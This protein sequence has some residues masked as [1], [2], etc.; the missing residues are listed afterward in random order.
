MTKAFLAGIADIPGG[1][2]Y[3][4]AT[5]IYIKKNF[6]QYSNAVDIDAHFN[7]TA[8]K[9]SDSNAAGIPR[10]L[11][12]AHM[13]EV[14]MLVKSI[15]ENGFVKVV[16]NGGMDT[17]LFPGLEVTVHGKR[18]VKG[19]FGAKP[20]HIQRGDEADKCIAL[21]DMYIDTGL[22]D[23]GEVIS[24]GD[25]VT[26]NSSVT[27]LG[28]DY[29]MGKAMDDRAGVAILLA[30]MR[31]L[32]KLKYNADVYFAATVQEELGT[33]GASMVGF[34]LAPDIGIAIDVT[35]GCTPDAGVA[36]GN[37]VPMDKGISI[38]VGPNIHPKLCEK[39][40]D[41]ANENNIGYVIEANPR[42][43]GTDARALQVAGAG[44]PSLLL[45]I[46][47][48]YMHTP[49]EVIAPKTVD[50][51]GKLIALFIASLGEDWKQWTNY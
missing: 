30:A 1:S 43:T 32:D 28:K 48:R 37:T 20:P 31:E 39:L 18:A 2:G 33:K 34:R 14:G 45:S 12:C 19:I 44:I 38:T 50:T 49:N 7:V 36:T 35:H 6:E 23:V 40:C 24:I 29:I 26:Y 10:I 22:S 42:P 4:E 16:T 15:E 17:R 11:L 27:E 9:V 13:D 51:A 8:R 25:V 41:V 47:L 3:E 46:P 5:A 21:D